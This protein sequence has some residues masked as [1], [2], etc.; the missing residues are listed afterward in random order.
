MATQA[1]V[2]NIIKSNPGITAVQIHKEL[3][4]LPGDAIKSLRLKHMITRERNKTGGFNLYTNH[5]NIN[6]NP[7]H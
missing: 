2:Y 3:K 5:D 4:S 1:E 7:N 6:I